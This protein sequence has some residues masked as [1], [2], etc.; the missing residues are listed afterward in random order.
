MRRYKIHFVCRGNTYRSRVAEAYFSTLQGSRADVSSSGIESWR[1]YHDG[2]KVFIEPYARIV[3][4]QLGAGEHLSQE[5][6]QTTDQL[7][8]EADIIIF[9]NQDVY[10]DAQKMFHFNPHKA[11]VWRVHDVSGADRSHHGQRYLHMLER[12]LGRNVHTIKHLCDQ[13]DRDVRL[14]WS[15]VVDETNTELGFRLPIRWIVDRGLWWRGCHAIITTPDKQYLV[16]KRSKTIVYSPGQ[17]DV[18]LGGGVD[19]GE[20]PLAA[21]QR[22]TKEELGLI[23]PPERYRVIDA[24]K[25]NSYHPRYRNH[26]RL[27]LTTYHAEVA[28]DA[29]NLVPDAKEVASVSLLSQRQLHRLLRRHYLVRLGRLKYGYTYINDM[30]RLIAAT[31]PDQASS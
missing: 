9:M 11:A 1:Y 27:F 4:D 18:T 21:I 24:R 13:L 26:T 16:E 25:W 22:E 14:S 15:D 10:R 8:G 7:L 6:T 2:P 31:T 29:L 3:A 12:H 20:T 23:L 28:S 30:V 5:W 19:S 17:I